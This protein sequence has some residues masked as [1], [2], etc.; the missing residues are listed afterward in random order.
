MFKPVKTS[1]VAFAIASAY[2]ASPHET[3]AQNV[4]SLLTIIASSVPSAMQEV[5]QE[6]SGARS[7]SKGAS[8]TAASVN[9][10]TFFRPPNS[11]AQ[12]P[13]NPGPAFNPPPQNLQPTF[14]TNQP[15]YNPPYQPNDYTP[16]ANNPLIQ[17]FTPPPDNYPQVDFF[18]PQQLIYYPQMPDSGSLPLI[19]YPQSNFYQ[20]TQP[21][22]NNQVQPR[23]Y[24]L[25]NTPSYPRQPAST[26]AQ[27]YVVPPE[28]AG[29]PQGSTINYGGVSYVIGNDGTM[30]PYG[31]NAR[32]TVQPTNP[33][34]YQIPA[35]YARMPQGSV[36]NYGGA[37]YMI[38]GDGTM[39]P[40]KVNS[41]RSA[42]PAFAAR[43]QIPAEYAGSPQGSVISY[44]GSNY[45]V[46]G[47]GTMTVYSGP[48][49]R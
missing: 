23:D 24:R 40:H 6:S 18:V 35:E 14:P 39:S 15:T 13:T 45:L 3:R 44:G 20:Q 11:G 12:P 19:Y 29:W 31:G 47:D 34:R 2:L 10:N 22:Y 8:V 42:Q 37:S 9:N 30:S 28:F 32:Q 7:D 21:I 1:L 48:L 4:G 16:P 38:G 41:D 27:R 25:M 36:I 49:S 33:A 5:P 26:V 46:G 43:Y 17:L